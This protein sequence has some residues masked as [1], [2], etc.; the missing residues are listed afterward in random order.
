MIKDTANKSR[1]D[2]SYPKHYRQ[3]DA[4]EL[5]VPRTTADSRGRF[6][7][8]EGD[9]RQKFGDPDGFHPSKH[10]LVVPAVG[11]FVQPVERVAKMPADAWGCVRM[12]SRWKPRPNP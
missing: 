9:F 7:N 10:R 8:W 12:H 6:G 1:C 11:S 5:N 2:G 3:R 4:I